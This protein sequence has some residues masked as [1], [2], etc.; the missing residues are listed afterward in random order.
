M[1]F[2]LNEL[3]AAVSKNLA[4]F[5]SREKQPPESNDYGVRVALQMGAPVVRF[6]FVTH[7]EIEV[8]YDVDLALLKREGGDYIYAGLVNVAE[9]LQAH[10]R[11][12]HLKARP[13]IVSGPCAGTLH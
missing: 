8:D 5:A 12:R 10:R 3:A 11:D 13:I 1:S 2:D 9:K 7:D 4:Q 6:S